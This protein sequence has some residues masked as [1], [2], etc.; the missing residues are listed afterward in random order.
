MNAIKHDIKHYYRTDLFGCGQTSAATLLS[1]YGK[2]VTPQQVIDAIPTLKNEAGEDWGTL[3]Q[4]RAIWCIGQGFKVDFYTADFQ[5][6][7]LSWAKFSR[8]ELLER[9]R[10]VKPLRNVAS[11]GPEFSQ[12]AMQI[13]IDLVEA[14]GEIHI[15]QYVTTKLIDELLEKGP[16]CA[17]VSYAVLHGEGRVRDTGPREVTPDD[18]NGHTSNHSIIIYGRDE[19][20]K[21]LIADSL[22]EPGHFA[23]ESEHLLCAMTAAQVECEN[24]MFVVTPAA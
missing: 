15:I 6:L 2:D 7:D 20:G 5:L 10:A 23:L 9:M 18:I 11:L 8:D 22:K 13:N 4:Q 16:I 3:A 24:A 21:Y 12:M 17:G 19:Q 14:G 1:H